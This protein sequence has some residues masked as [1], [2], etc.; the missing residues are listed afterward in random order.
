M[1][2][3]LET[4]LGKFTGESW[5]FLRHTATAE[6]LQLRMMRSAFD[7]LV[8][9]DTLI[10]V[11]ANLGVYS[12]FMGSSGGCSKIIAFEP[13]P[14]T[15]DELVANL[16]L[17]FGTSADI[18]AHNLAASVDRSEARFD[19]RREFGPGNR[20]L[21]QVTATPKG[22]EVVVDTVPLD[23]IVGDGARDMILKIDVEGHEIKAMKGARQ[24]IG[25]RC[26]LAQIEC[27]AGREQQRA[28]MKTFMAKRDFRLLC[29]IKGDHLFLHESHWEN[30]AEPLMEVYYQHFDKANALLGQLA[31]LGVKADLRDDVSAQAV[32]LF[33]GFDRMRIGGWRRRMDRVAGNKR[34]TG[35]E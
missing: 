2:K 3:V 29:R 17:N 20:I 8:G 1:S 19:V 23:E 11:G 28:R 30:A 31:V 12:V 6:P 14:N 32:E 24:T 4:S 26:A 10:D 7:L 9:V 13:S 5:R 22:H 27:W 21:S 25:K 33:N 34:S 18:V 16:T 15:Y 35:D